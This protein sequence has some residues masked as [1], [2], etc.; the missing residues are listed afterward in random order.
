LS[1]LLGDNKEVMTHQ[2][3][4]ATVVGTIVNPGNAAVVITA[5]RV[6]GSPKTF[7]V[8]V[9]ALDSAST[10]AGLIRSALAFDSAVSTMYLV[11]GTGA[12]VV[13]TE[14]T[15][16]TNDATLNISITNGTCTGLTPALT[17]TDTQAGVGIL[18]GY[19]T[20]ADLRST[21]A[22]NFESTYTTDDQLL[23]DLIT[24]TSRAIDKQTGRYFYKSAAHEVKYFTA[25]NNFR[26][27]TDDL[28]SVTALYTDNLNGD[29]TYPYTWSATDYDLWPYDADT[30][31]EPEPFRFIET[32]PQGFYQFPYGIRKGVK[33]DGIFGWPA[34]PALIS[35]ACLL[36]CERNYKRLQ[37]PLGTSSMSQLGVVSIKVP[38]PDP[39]VEAML[40]NYRTVAV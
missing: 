19:C 9:S 6:T 39:D 12:D 4:T 7:A 5:V 24:A 1:I 3:E 31:S 38:P 22:L 18:N 21:P 32:A 34:V 20:L 40:N 35:K 36:W 30:L 10:V 26:L 33:I 37:T 2:I 28:V 25:R 15:D 8:A 13:L 11:S 27:F 29:R 16:A 17:S 14:R 23:C